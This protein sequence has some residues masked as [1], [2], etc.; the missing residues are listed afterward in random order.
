MLKKKKFILLGIFLFL[1]IGTIL[2]I[3]FLTRAK[4]KLTSNLIAAT[5]SEKI[6][7]AIRYI[8]T[9][10]YSIITTP[11][12][13]NIFST[14]LLP[15][16]LVFRCKNTLYDS[17][18]RLIKNITE[19]LTQLTNLKN[20]PLLVAIC[21]DVKILQSLKLYDFFQIVLKDPIGNV[22]KY[23]TIYY[24]YIN[25]SSTRTY[26]AY[27]TYLLSNKLQSLAKKYNIITPLSE[28]IFFG[29]DMEIIQVTNLFDRF[30][31]CNGL[32][33]LE[34]TG[35]YYYTSVTN[36]KLIQSPL[37]KP[38]ITDDFHFYIS[39]NIP[40]KSTKNLSDFDGK[41][42]INGWPGVV[43]QITDGTFCDF[44][45]PCGLDA[46]I[47]YLGYLGFYQTISGKIPFIMSN[48]TV[49]LYK[50]N[51]LTPS[52]QRLF[53][54]Y[55]SPPYE[56]ALWLKDPTRWDMAKQQSI[57]QQEIFWA[58]TVLT[59]RR[60]FKKKN[61][62]IFGQNINNPFQIRYAAYNFLVSEM[63]GL[64]VQAFKEDVYIQILLDP[65][66]QSP[67]RAYNYARKMFLLS[68]MKC[69]EWFGESYCAKL[70][71]YS[72]NINGSQ[73]VDNGYQGNV[74]KP[75]GACLPT[76]CKQS[77]VTKQN[78]DGNWINSCSNQGHCVKKGICACEGVT[79]TMQNILENVSR[80]SKCNCQTNKDI[81]HDFIS[82]SNSQLTAKII[83]DAI[84][85]LQSWNFLC[86]DILQNPF[87]KILHSKIRYFKW[88][89][90]DNG[91][92]EVIVSGSANPDDGAMH[93]EETII[94]IGPIKN[95]LKKSNENNI[96]QSYLDI[97]NSILCYSYDQSVNKPNTLIP[98]TFQSQ[99]SQYIY[100]N[101]WTPKNIFNVFNAG[102]ISKNNINVRDIIVKFI[103]EATQFVGISVYT[104]RIF[105][106]TSN[107]QILDLVQACILAKKRGAFVFIITDADQVVG[108]PGFA[109][110]DT[111]ET[112]IKFLQAG[113]PVWLAK[114]PFPFSAFHDKN[115]I[116]DLDYPKIITDT[117][118]WTRGGMGKTSAQ[119]FIDK[120]GN[121]D[122]TIIIDLKN[123]KSFKYQYIANAIYASFNH[124]INK[125][126]SFQFG[127][128]AVPPI[129]V[130]S[131]VHS[132]IQNQLYYKSRPYIAV[133]KPTNDETN[134]N[135]E[136]PISCT[137]NNQPCVNCNENT[138]QNK[139]IGTCDN[140][141]QGTC[142]RWNYNL[143]VEQSKN[144]ALKTGQ[145]YIQAG[146]WDI[147][148]SMPKSVKLQ[149]PPNKTSGNMGYAPTI[150]KAEIQTNIKNIHPPTNYGRT[151]QDYLLGNK[152]FWS[153]NMLE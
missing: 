82:S 114:Q 95:R 129:T 128:P 39:E 73:V 106:G 11:N 59:N 78:T 130:K 47:I 104:L 147:L 92:Y 109:G 124:F 14:K 52:P 2:L 38:N 111:S 33:S 142:R 60:T 84:T 146:G 62:K 64:I 81:F 87:P 23:G 135:P 133:G 122:T 119:G 120:P 140:C 96:I 63:V 66:Q 10:P 91:N 89:G 116:I 150:T 94:S 19:I 88:V 68:G 123:D 137:I 97:Y 22:F 50:T 80:P 54:I 77:E 74:S 25:Y 30:D 90:E 12:N 9:D 131:N 121:I 15:R 51:L 17:T 6:L 76:D 34:T 152:L 149:Y 115:C 144:I 18:G 65:N 145:N 32:L 75:G 99:F 151:N 28:M 117:T 138:L 93:N 24:S 21:E 45:T 134:W 107:N 85:Y 113:I 71:I 112:V 35:N 4:K 143:M 148:N 72:S 136:T 41:L 61:P 56:K 26:L 139:C 46:N 102:S 16:I 49:N 29:S 37:I 13:R 126:E 57:L 86:I 40:T 55:F 8:S 31:C 48:N 70:C 20:P 5:S 105:G 1:L 108:E 103:S 132:C 98:Y 44:K 58:Y 79:D 127:G 83:T 43:S 7:G 101:I 118:N 125:F 153:I 3:Y 141:P 27:I 69:S 36:A 110:P 67:C 42:S 100:Y 53:K